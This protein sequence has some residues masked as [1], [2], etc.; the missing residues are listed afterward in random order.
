VEKIKELQ[1]LEAL[2]ESMKKAQEQM[3]AEIKELKQTI[4]FAFEGNHD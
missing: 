2:M 4:H 1:P 3:F